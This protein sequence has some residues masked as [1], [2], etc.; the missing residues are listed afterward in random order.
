MGSGGQS[1][2]SFSALPRN[3][4]ADGV[5]DHDTAFAYHLFEVAVADAVFAIPADADQNDVGRETA[6]FE[7]R[8]GGDPGEGTPVSPPADDQC[9]TA[10]SMASVLPRNTREC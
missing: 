9:N 2:R 1:L 6:A 4:F 3:R 5:I 7:V 8:H 10:G